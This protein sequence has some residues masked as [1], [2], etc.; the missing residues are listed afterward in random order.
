MLQ[1]SKAQPLTAETATALLDA[2]NTP[3]VHVYLDEWLQQQYE[4]ALKMASAIGSPMTTQPGEK[5]LQWLGWA[6]GIQ[7]CQHHLTML[8]KRS[9][10]VLQ[11]EVENL[12]READR[13]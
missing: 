8:R 1:E 12:T 10:F 5:A 7:D 4:Q 9:A 3:A 6:N 13:S 11:Q 2:L